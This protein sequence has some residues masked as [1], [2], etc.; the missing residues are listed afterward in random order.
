M[1]RL[2]FV[3]LEQAAKMRR[4]DVH[5][6]GDSEAA[7]RSHFDGHLRL[8]AKRNLRLALDNNDEVGHRLALLV[9]R[10][11]VVITFN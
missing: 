5:K 2:P 3:G 7:E 11:C 10:L 9:Q 6:S 4:P 1:R 8:V